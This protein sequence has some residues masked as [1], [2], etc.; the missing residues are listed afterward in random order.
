MNPNNPLQ[1]YFRQPKIYMALPSKGGQQVL[2]AWRGG[3]DPGRDW[4]SDTGVR[5]R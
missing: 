4:Q 2:P 3:S 1:K 5:V